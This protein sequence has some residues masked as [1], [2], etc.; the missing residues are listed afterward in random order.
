MT[1]AI[2]GPKRDRFQLSKI[3]PA[4]GDPCRTCLTGCVGSACTAS[5]GG[6]P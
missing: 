1:D 6:E 3:E 4:G 2:Y 5:S